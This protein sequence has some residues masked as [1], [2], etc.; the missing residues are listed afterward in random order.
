MNILMPI[1]HRGES[2]FWVSHGSP[3]TRIDLKLCIFTIGNVPVTLGVLAAF[4]DSCPYMAVTLN[5]ISGSPV[6]RI[7][8]K[9]CIFT[10]GNVPVTLGVL[11]DAQA[12]AL[13]PY[14]EVGEKHRLNN[15]KVIILLLLPLVPIV[16]GG[17]QSMFSAVLRHQ[18]P[19]QVGQLCVSTGV[20]TLGWRRRGVSI[21]L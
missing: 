3:V 19:L 10:I 12:A 9:L 6:T 8:L 13:C 1:E 17:C 7:D 5:S 16:S 11:A 4:W 21:C 18:L 20:R 2:S 15:G 14:M